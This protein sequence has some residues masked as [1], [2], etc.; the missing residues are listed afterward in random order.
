MQKALLSPKGLISESKEGGLIRKG[1]FFTKSNDMDMNDTFSVRLL[2][3]L[4][5]QHTIF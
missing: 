4:W 1:D 5:I 3:I 2:H